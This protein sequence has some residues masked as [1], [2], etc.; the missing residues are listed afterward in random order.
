MAVDYSRVYGLKRARDNLG[1]FIHMLDSETYKIL[2]EE[3]TRANAEV[4][5]ETPVKSGALRRGSSIYVDTTS[6]VR[7]PTIRGKSEVHAPGSGYDYSSKQ[8]ENE[9]YRHPNGG[10]AHFIRDP[11]NRMVERLYRRLKDEIKYER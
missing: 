6:G 3:A 2:M 10:K 9:S 5:L 1:R 7:T 4:Y 8:H 11:F